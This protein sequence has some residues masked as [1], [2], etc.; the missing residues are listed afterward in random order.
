MKS[1]AEQELIYNRAVRE[2]LIRL[3]SEGLEYKVEHTMQRADEP[4]MVWAEINY[5]QMYDLIIKIYGE[6]AGNLIYRSID[7]VDLEEVLVYLINE[8]WI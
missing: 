3:V 8:A 2:L 4:P 5:N 1:L 6:T 7:F